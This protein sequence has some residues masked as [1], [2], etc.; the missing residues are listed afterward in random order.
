MV[1]RV[2]WLGCILV[3]VSVAVQMDGSGSGG[4]HQHVGQVRHRKTNTFGRRNVAEYLLKMLKKGDDDNNLELPH[5]L[6]Y[7]QQQAQSTTITEETI[8]SGDSNTITITNQP[9][10]T[11]PTVFG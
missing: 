8:G 6:Q 7:L 10:T 5:D 9:Q 11:E 4:M 3:G 1:M 2:G